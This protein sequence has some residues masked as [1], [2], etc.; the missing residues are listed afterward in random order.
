V[1]VG[2]NSGKNDQL[3]GEAEAEDLFF[4][5]RS[6]PGAHVILKREGKAEEPGKMAIKEAAGLAAY[7]CKAPPNA[8]SVPV[9]YTTIRHVSKKP[10][11]AA[12]QVEIDNERT[13]VVAPRKIPPTNT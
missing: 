7:W 13:L 2:R 9:D 3:T 12:G 8:P 5:A 11:A 6:L 1:L 4:H 10:G